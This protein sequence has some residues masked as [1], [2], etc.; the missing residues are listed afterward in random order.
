[1][2]QSYLAACCNQ[3]ESDNKG[4]I[5]MPGAENSPRDNFAVDSLAGTQFRNVSQH[6]TEEIKNGPEPLAVRVTNLDLFINNRL[7]IFDA[8]LNNANV[9]VSARFEFER[10]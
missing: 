1:M 9:L 10:I 4:T 2:G 3:S 6:V 5:Q 7:E 8:A